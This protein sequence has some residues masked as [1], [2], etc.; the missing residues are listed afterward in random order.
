MR[1]LE[2]TTSARTALIHR[3]SS[4]P[5]VS[6]PTRRGHSK[7]ICY[8][9]LSALS[10][11]RVISHVSCVNLRSCETTKTDKYSQSSHALFN[12][13]FQFQFTTWPNSRLTPPRHSFPPILPFGS[14]R[15]LSIMVS[16]A[17]TSCAPKGSP[18][19]S[20]PQ[21][22]EKIAPSRKLKRKSWISLVSS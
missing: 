19:N 3:S 20:T 10:A 1:P 22:H 21:S 4:T 8:L 5:P 18:S 13:S 9:D 6:R 14:A 15:L 11:Y 12:P 17:T 2:G 7:L 16:T